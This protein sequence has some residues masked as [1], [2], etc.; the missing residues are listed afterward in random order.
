MADEFS[1]PSNE[2]WDPYRPRYPEL[3]GAR[4]GWR[5]Y[6]RAFLIRDEARAIVLDTG[7]GPSTSPAH[8][9]F[10]M[11]GALLD[12][13]AAAGVAPP[14]VET[15]VISH[16]H[17]DH[18]GGACT[19]DGKPSFPNARY[20][21]HRAD[22]EWIRSEAET[23]NESESIWTQ[24]L[25]P[26]EASGQLIAIGDAFEVAPH[27]RTRHLPGHTPGHQGLELATDAERL[28]LSADS[29]HHP[30]QLDRPEWAA[31]M[32]NDPDQATEI[33][34]ALLTELV[35]SGRLIAPTHFAEPFGRVVVDG[36]RVVWQPD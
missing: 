16:V 30:A 24:L 9:W 21:I 33:R 14:D 19:A 13:L 20:L 5:L 27:I 26:I 1:S 10:G 25:Q 29:F 23:G 7:V 35:G 34:R 8:E 28:L 3:F 2:A 6:V 12:E 18:I 32:D 11:P 31:T 15:V 17:D 22:V 4:G 36:E